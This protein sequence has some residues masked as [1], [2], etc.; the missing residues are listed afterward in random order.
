MLRAVIFPEVVSNVD[1]LLLMSSSICFLKY[2]GHIRENTDKAVTFFIKI[3]FLFVGW[4][5]FHIFN[6]FGK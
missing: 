1:D 4:A 3:V 2:F 5:D 6:A